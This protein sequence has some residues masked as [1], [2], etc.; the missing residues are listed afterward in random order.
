MS[1][2]SLIRE[3]SRANLWTNYKFRQ[4]GLINVSKVLIGSYYTATKR[5][6]VVELVAEAN[7]SLI[8]TYSGK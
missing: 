2:V 5:E 8:G 4:L 3:V 6:R 7:R 1:L